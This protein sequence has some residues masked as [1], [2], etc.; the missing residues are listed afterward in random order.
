MFEGWTAWIERRLGRRGRIGASGTVVRPAVTELDRAAPPAAH[1]PA[2]LRRV[3]RMLSLSTA[4]RDYARR[5]D[6]G[7][8]VTARPAD[9]MPLAE[10]MG[11]E[12]WAWQYARRL[13]GQT[14]WR[15]RPDADEAI[16]RAVVGR[17]MVA[18]IQTWERAMA[19]LDARMA[20]ARVGGLP[21]PP[22]LAVPD[23]VRQAIEARRKAAVERIGRRRGRT[24]DGSGGPVPV[25]EEAAH[26]P[27][28]PAKPT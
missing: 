27:P 1:K 17:E 20:Y 15:A 24:E 18:D 9:L 22:S 21:L 3:V 26:H 5:L 6:A 16:E 19:V 25:P 2:S 14:P 23:D 12:I 4:S 8:F 13:T 10:A 7:L 11:P 28:L